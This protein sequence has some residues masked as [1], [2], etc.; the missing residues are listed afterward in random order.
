MLGAARRPRLPPSAS[1]RLFVNGEARQAAE[2]RVRPVRAQ[3]GLAGAAVRYAHDHSEPA[4]AGGLYPGWRGLHHCGPGG[5]NLEQA[6]RVQQDRRVRQ[7][8][9]DNL[10]I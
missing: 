9:L 5:V 10:I 6:C 4:A 2:D 3:L 1:H 7:P 8:R